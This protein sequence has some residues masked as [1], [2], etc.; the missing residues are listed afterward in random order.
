MPSTV[1]G[2]QGGRGERAVR[3]GGGGGVVLGGGGVVWVG[4]GV[5]GPNIASSTCCEGEQGGGGG[6][7]G[8]WVG[9][10]K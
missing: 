1:Q 10:D 4:V 6:W 3:L 7:V 9:C 8:G 2:R 5:G